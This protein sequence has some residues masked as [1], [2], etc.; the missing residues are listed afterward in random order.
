MLFCLVESRV[1][2][3]NHVVASVDS[4]SDDL[5]DSL[6]LDP[7]LTLG[8][9]DV[10]VSSEERKV[11]ACLVHAHPHRLRRLADEAWDVSTSEHIAANAIL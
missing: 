1:E 3:V 5:L 8:V 4:V 7:R 11:H 2:I 6:S 10:A 9:I